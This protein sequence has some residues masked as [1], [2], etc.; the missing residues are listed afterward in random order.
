MNY[1]ET[2]REIG[3]D[4]AIAPM[5]L[6]EIL[7]DINN[8]YTIHKVKK[9]SGGYRTIEAP[10]DELK[11]I[12]RRLM[13]RYYNKMYVSKCAHGFVKNR[14]IAT[15]ALPHAGC[16][17]LIKMDLE[18]FFPNITLHEL[19][20]K[21]SVKKMKD[22]ERLSLAFCMLDGRLPQGAP[23]SPVLSNVFMVGFDIAL[24]N[25]AES[26]GCQYTRYADDLNISHKKKRISFMIPIIK[27]LISK[28]NGIYLN[29]RKTGFFHQGQ[30]MKVVGM[31]V[32][33]AGQVQPTKEYRMKI[34]AMKHQ[35]VDTKELQGMEA[36]VNQSIK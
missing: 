15:C 3:L 13:H 23:T 7:R 34:R 8:E 18:N 25:I 28:H 30:R 27:E 12:Q 17:S 10:S 16:E 19:L 32:N 6:I 21:S 5:R 35:G 14:N 9:K 26:M 33:K 22:K 11:E 20:K 36:F 1:A 24:S 2:I 31:I 29:D 4:I